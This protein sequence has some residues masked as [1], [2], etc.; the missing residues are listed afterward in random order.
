MGLGSQRQTNIPP[1]RPEKAAESVQYLTV[2]FRVILRILGLVS[3]TLGIEVSK[4]VQIPLRVDW[5]IILFVPLA[6]I[7][8]NAFFEFMA[9]ASV[10]IANIVMGLVTI[11]TLVNRAHLTGTPKF[12]PLDVL[13]YAASIAILAYFGYVASAWFLGVVYIFNN[14][15]IRR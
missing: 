3:S 14:L 11:I 4:S 5:L 1:T 2:D 10:W 7:A 6:A 15:Y 13:S 12:K 8:P 9:T